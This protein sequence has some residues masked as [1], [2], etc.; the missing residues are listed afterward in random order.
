MGIE[1]LKN[2][3][4]LIEIF[5]KK[6]VGKREGTNC[7]IIKIER[8]INNIWE[9]HEWYQRSHSAL[10]MAEHLKKYNGNERL[11][12]QGKEFTYQELITLLE[13]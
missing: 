13:N 12:I 1:R 8:L 2:M 6:N 4:K 9:W 5:G 11:R 3:K 10:Y 7:A